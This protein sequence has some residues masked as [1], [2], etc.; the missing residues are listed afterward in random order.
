MGRSVVLVLGIAACT[1][2]PFALAQV[3]TPPADAAIATTADEAPDEA[4]RKEPSAFGQVMGML[5]LLLQEAADKQAT[6]KGAIAPTLSPEQ[7]AVTVRVTPVAGSNTFYA[8]KPREDAVAPA[9]AAGPATG[10]A[11]QL[12]E[13]APAGGN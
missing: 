4:T 12:A 1:V 13:Q 7:S 9:L 5:T 3:R 8:R 11:A 6:S 2:S 10:H